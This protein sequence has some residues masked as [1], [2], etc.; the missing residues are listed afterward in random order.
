[1]H[2]S[3][4]TGLYPFGHGVRNNGNFVLGE[5]MPTLATALRDAGYQ[6]GAFVS[7]FALDRRYGLARGFDHYDDRFELDAATEP[8][9]RP[10]SG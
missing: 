10:P 9:P 8:P 5:R 3:L 1:V 7:A 4:F 6:T 2:A